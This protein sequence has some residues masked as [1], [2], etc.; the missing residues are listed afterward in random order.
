MGIKSIKGQQQKQTVNV[1]INIPEPKTKKRR[2][3]TKKS[4]ID[5]KNLSNHIRQS[6]TG[7]VIYQP[8]NNLPRPITFYSQ[9]YSQPL[10]NSIMEE[11]RTRTQN[12]NTLGSYN[13]GLSSNR[14]IDLMNQEKVVNILTNDD[15]TT[16]YYDNSTFNA[17][18]IHPKLPNV[19]FGIVELNNEEKSNNA[20]SNLVAHEKKSKVELNV[21]NVLDE[22]LVEEYENEIEGLGT[23]S[24]VF[25]PVEKKKR[26]RKPKPKVKEEQKI[27]YPI[28]EYKA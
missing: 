26:G 25:I 4:I 23:E 16:N 11:N 7:Q 27:Y 6:N 9:S 13:T 28:T 18:E 3:R 19:N 21:N 8:S 5:T 24:E 22:Q 1:K 14:T 12:S 20:L 15:P 10:T 2:K 17:G